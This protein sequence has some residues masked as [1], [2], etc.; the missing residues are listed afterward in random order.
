LQDPRKQVIEFR[1]LFPIRIA[2]RLD[3]PEQVDMVLG[4]G[5]RDRRA[6][7]H[8]ITEDTP[9]VA[10]VKVDGHR[11]PDRVRAFHSSDP[12]LDELSAYVTAG[13]PDAPRPLPRT[14]AAA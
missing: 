11:D 5:V 6:A 8:E 12:D 3:V 13:H 9:G 14:K 7:A 2:M 10:W 4:D 1:H